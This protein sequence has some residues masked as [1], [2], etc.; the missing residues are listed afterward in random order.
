MDLI[1][2]RLC[3][4]KEALSLKKIFTMKELKSEF[5]LPFNDPFDKKI[6]CEIFDENDI[7]I[8][9]NVLH[10]KSWTQDWRCSFYE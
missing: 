3:Y 8:K 5:Y 2:I 4:F 9:D 6:E 1:G 10:P 7:K